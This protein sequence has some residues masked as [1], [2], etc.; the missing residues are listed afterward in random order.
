MK[1]LL[2]FLRPYLSRLI[3]C[4]GLL[5]IF[6][7]VS[8]FSLSL[9]LPFLNTVFHKTTIISNDILGRLNNLFA[10][11]PPLSTILKLSGIVV[12]VFIFKGIIGYSQKYLGAKIEEDVKRDIRNTTYSHLQF[13]SLDYFHQAQTGKLTSKLIYDISLLQGT[14]KDGILGLLRHFLLAAVYFSICLYISWK[15]LLATIFIFPLLYW[16]VNRLSKKLRQRSDKLQSRMGDIAQTVQESVS[17]IKIVKAFSKEKFEIGKFFENTLSYYKAALKFERT[18]LIGIPVTELVNAIA[19]A[20]ILLFAGYEIFVIGSLAPDRFLLFLVCS[21]SMMQPLKQ[22]ISAN[23]LVQKG[24]QAI[25][26]IGKVLDTQPSV[27]EA[28]DA[29]TID[30]FK[31]EIVFNDVYFNYNGVYNAVNGVSFSI[32]KGSS[33]AF[34]GP[35]GAGKSTLTDLLLR[36]YDP[37]S[38]SIEIDGI[39]LRRVKLEALRNMVGLVTQEPILFNDT[40]FRN[41]AYGIENPDPAK[42]EVAARLANAHDF[43]MRLLAQ[44]ETTV[45][46]RGVKLSGGERQRIAIARALYRS[47]K[48]L[49]FD[50][51]TSHLDT[52]SERLVQDAIER[53]LSGRTSII[54]AHRLSTV[55]NTDRIFVI[56]HGKVVEEGNHLELI[57]KGGLYKRLAEKD[58]A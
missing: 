32:K 27:L 46:E 18:S 7:L 44:Y 34:V 58:L 31:H 8:G 26:R 52:E 9:L 35:S 6:A 38:G 4:F 17:G 1:R 37:D 42:V 54:I 41:I 14:I 13:L 53:L 20:I 10:N 29:I 3:L 16:F 48:I 5:C 2:Q 15:L 28:S 50:E 56:E 21:L 23:V 47:P 30:D 12:F 51:A 43:I 55:R 36:F 39:D 19:A 40:I 11:D 57:K 25:S 24:L 45:G 22:I 33:V 49:I